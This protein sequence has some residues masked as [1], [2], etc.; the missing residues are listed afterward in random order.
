MG[1]RVREP[2]KR[3]HKAYFGGRAEPT[4]PDAS[5]NGEAGVETHRGPASVCEEKGGGPAHS[6]GPPRLASGLG[7]SEGPD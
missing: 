2:R 4:H 6:S 3:L 1:R 5:T 7:S